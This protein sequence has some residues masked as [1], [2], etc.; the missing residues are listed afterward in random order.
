MHLNAFDWFDLV[1][2]VPVG[3]LLGFTIAALTRGFAKDD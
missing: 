2:L 1:L 3:I